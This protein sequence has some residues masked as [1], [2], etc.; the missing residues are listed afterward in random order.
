MSRSSRPT[1]NARTARGEI[2]AD[3]GT[4]LWVVHRCDHPRGLVEGEVLD[5]RVEVDLETVDPNLILGGI[6]PVPERR[7][8]PVQGDATIDDQFFARSSRAVAGA[9]E[10]AL[11]PFDRHCL[12][13]GLGRL[14][15]RGLR[16]RLLGVPLDPEERRQRR[17]GGQ[18][19]QTQPLE[20]G[21]RRRE[22]R[23]ADPASPPAP[24][25]RRGPCPRAPGGPRR[26]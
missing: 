19:R 23:S 24:P 21:R 13:G 10:E 17:Q 12:S 15:R 6:T 3:V 26:S 16:V 11:Q 7:H 4:P 5:V 14:R 18:R 1:G 9:G 8:V 22:Q 20:E 2:R 25:P